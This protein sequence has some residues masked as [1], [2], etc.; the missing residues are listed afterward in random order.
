[1][2]ADELI[3]AEFEGIRTDVVRGGDFASGRR[4][5]WRRTHR[6]ALRHPPPAAGR[7]LQHRRRR[8]PGARA[9]WAASCGTP[10]RRPK[11]YALTNHHVV[12]PPDMSASVVGTTEVGQ[13]LGEASCSDCCDDRIGKYAGGGMTDDRDEALVQLT[14][15]ITWQ[16]EILEIGVVAGRHTVTQAEAATGTYAVRKHGPNP[17]HRRGDLRAR[18]L[19]GRRRQHHDRRSEPAPRRRHPTV[20]FVYEGDSGAVLVNGANE[21]VGLIDARD[22]AGNGT[23]F[24]I[25]HVLDRFAAESVAVEVA[26][27]TTPGTVNTVPGAAMVTVPPEVSEP[28]SQSGADGEVPAAPVLAGGGSARPPPPHPA[29]RR[30]CTGSGAAGCCRWRRPDP[31]VLGHVAGDLGRSAAGRRLL[32]LWD[33]H[34]AELRRLLEA[35]RRV[36]TTWHRS[37]ASALFQLLVR[38]GR[39]PGVRVPEQV[40]GRPSTRPGPGPRDV[41]ARRG[42]AAARRPRRRAPP[43]PDLGGLTRRRII[44]GVA[45]TGGTGWERDG[46]RRG[47]VRAG[48][49]AARRPRGARAAL[50]DEE[51]ARHA[52]RAGRRLPRGAARRPGDHRRPADDH[53]A[54]E[55]ARAARRRADGGDRRRGCPRRWSLRPCRS[56]A[57]PSRLV[58]S[59]G[60]L[61]NALQPPARRCPASPRP[62]SPSSSRT[63]PASSSICCCC[64]VL[65]LSPPVA[66][67]VTVF[68]VVERAFVPGEVTDPTRPD[69]DRVTVRSR[70]VA[71][72]RSP[73]P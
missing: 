23:A 18:R 69:F 20:F 47:D 37:G 33:T 62:R 63:C 12:N 17:P 16:A 13:P 72:R 6:G 4:S 28:R 36:A 61:A 56:S 38:D 9:R 14:A 57:R 21:V 68:G 3:P 24:P 50:L 46:R 64:E 31:A 45:A 66:A 30:A 41:P 26:T 52:G 1:M 15:G 44:G 27:A 67:V 42:P 73:T 5:T 10:P 51:R 39:G 49:R 58:A 70:P 8:Q 2:P 48:G 19:H 55:A 34:R 59:F 43:R 22:D 11:I 29:A 54:A 53:G 60:D 35:N 32:A 71:D 40:H 65:E 7:W 25:E